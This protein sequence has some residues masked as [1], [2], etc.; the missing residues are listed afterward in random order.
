MYVCARTS[1]AGRFLL[2]LL[3]GCSLSAGGCSSGTAPTE[4][5]PPATKHLKHIESLIKKG[6]EP[7]SSPKIGH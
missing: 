7:K 5:R 4:N 6:A 1:S 2:T 3:M